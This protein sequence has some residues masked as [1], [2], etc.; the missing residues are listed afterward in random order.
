[1]KTYVIFL[2]GINV[3]GKN[4]IAMADLRTFLEKLGYGN[5]V[6]YINSG[7]VIV[8]SGKTATAIE[9]EIE[10]ELV[11][12]FKFDSA[13]I[14]ILALTHQQLQAVVDDMPKE[15]SQDPADYYRDI[16]FLIK[17]SEQEAFAVFDPLEG[18]DKVWV[19]KGVIY[20]QRLG[21]LR[22]KSRLGK[23]IGTPPYKSMTI[24]TIG[25]VN[26]L[27]GIMDSRQS[28]STIRCLHLLRL[29]GSLTDLCSGCP[30]LSDTFSGPKSY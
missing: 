16:V 7:N 26:K 14:K 17:I 23:I 4:K 15:F 25:T 22:T 19:G 27:L 20:S 24:R 8:D 5:V 18:V 30:V 6:S 28:P 12:T 11:K 10:Q 29:A 13:L 9:D 21:T 1:M 3:G 2:R